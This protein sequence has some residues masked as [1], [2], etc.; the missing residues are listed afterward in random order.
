MHLQISFVLLVMM[1]GGVGFVGVSWL[2]QGAPVPMVRVTPMQPSPGLPTFAESVERGARQA[3]TESK[4]SAGD[5]DPE[6]D[7]LRLELMQAAN[8]YSLSPCSPVIKANLVKAL[9]AYATAVADKT[10]CRFMTCGG[11]PRVDAGAE[12]FLTPL[13]K[14]ARAAVAEAFDK[15]GITVKDFPASLKLTLLM[16][17]GGQG[18]ATSAC[19][20]TAGKRS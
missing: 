8:A 16:V 1:A 11:G 6:R 20:R 10:G 9:T 3:W 2:S 15:G 18:D 5:N 19:A 7:A 13:D 14:R 4:T 17:A 12:M